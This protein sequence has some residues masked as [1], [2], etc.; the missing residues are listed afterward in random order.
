M[1][2]DN[3][4][5]IRDRFKKNKYSI[6]NSTIDD[7][8]EF[9]DVCTDFME[10]FE[11]I[12]ELVLTQE[13][14]KKYS[15]EGQ[16]ELMSRINSVT[17][18]NAELNNSY[19]LGEEDSIGNDPIEYTKRMAIFTEMCNSCAHIIEEYINKNDLRKDKEFKDIKNTLFSMKKDAIEKIVANSL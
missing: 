9:Y 16:R 19:Y 5:R 10:E 3:V 6:E 14:I 11:E 17:E 15:K 7:E 1:N 4:S 18:L 13:N 2:L 12:K 8:E